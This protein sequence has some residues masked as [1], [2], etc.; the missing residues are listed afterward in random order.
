[1]YGGNVHQSMMMM[2]M[3]MVMMTDIPTQ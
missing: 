1:M 3:M 2:M